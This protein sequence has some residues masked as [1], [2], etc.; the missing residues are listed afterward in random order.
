[1]K[2]L[3]YPSLC[4]T[5]DWDCGPSI[6][7]SVLLYYGTFVREGELIKLSG[8]DRSGTYLNGIFKVL[9]KHG[10]GYTAEIM[11]IIKL[12]AYIDN[13]VPVVLMVQAWSD[14]TI[15]DWKNDWKNGHFV[16]L[17]GYQEDKLI[18]ADPYSAH[19]VYLT[20]DEL[21]DRW[22]DIDTINN[23]Y[24]HYGIAI[25]GKKPT[26]YQSKLVRMG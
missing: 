7:Q 4:Q 17:I 21:N 11:D 20:L 14:K 19:R 8:A 12:K 22:H 23:K 26:Y 9:I 2:I 15:T 16:T 3:N 24:F 1:M 18:F 10:L 25:Y 13:E 5:Y 6:L